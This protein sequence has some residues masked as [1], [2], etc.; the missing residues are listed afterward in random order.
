MWWH[1]AHSFTFLCSHHHHL[2]PEHFAPGKTE[3][4]YPLSSNSILLCNPNILICLCE[5]NYSVCACRLQLCLTLCDPMD[6][7]PPGSSLQGISKARILERVAIS[8][9][10]GS[11]QPGMEPESSASPT[12]AGGYFTT[13][14]PGKPLTTLRTSYKWNHAVFAFLGL[15]YFT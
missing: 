6:C 10:R 13:Q 1:L 11:C 12:L 8:F 3:T 7:S 14:P 9:S 5:F 4:Q 2:S 15:V